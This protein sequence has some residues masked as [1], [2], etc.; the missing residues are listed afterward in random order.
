M[1]VESLA[2]RRH[3]SNTATGRMRPSHDQAMQDNDVY[4]RIQSVGWVRVQG[5]AAGH[6]SGLLLLNSHAM[7]VELWPDSA[8]FRCDHCCFLVW[9]VSVRET[10]C[11]LTHTP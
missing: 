11:L 10:V 4:V 1:P 5:A 8:T 7:D 3:P 9:N 2:M 6:A